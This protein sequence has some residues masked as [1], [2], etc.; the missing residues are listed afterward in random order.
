MTSNLILIGE[1]K[2]KNVNNKIRKSTSTKIANKRK[3]LAHNDENKSD[4]ESELDSELL[5]H[6]DYYE[7]SGGEEGENNKNKNSDGANDIIQVN[8]NSFVGELYKKKL[9][10]GSK[11]DNNRQ[12][13]L[14]IYF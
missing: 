3:K 13:D 9:G 14:I 12:I 2:L 11:G 5:D 7:E 6:V 10:S 4:D 8:C 1:N